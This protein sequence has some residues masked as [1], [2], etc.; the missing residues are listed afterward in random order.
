MSQIT[1][2]ECLPEDRSAFEQCTFELQEDEKVRQSHV[3]KDPQEIKDV[4]FEHVVKTAKESEGKIY[5]GEKDGKVVGYIVV[6]TN[7]DGSPALLLKKYGYVMDFV[8]LR[9][10]QGQGVGRALMAQAEEYIRSKGLEWMHLD[11]TVG[12]PAHDFY[13]KSGYR[14][15]DIR[16]EKKLK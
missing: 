5:V 14:D 12:N 4:Y 9:E 2:R 11:V 13:I 7:E 10:Y 6:I 3:W 8:V 15:K 16:M 1:V